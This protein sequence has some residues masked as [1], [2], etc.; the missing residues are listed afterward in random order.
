MRRQP[1]LTTR[2]ARPRQL[3]TDTSHAV[4]TRECQSDPP[5]LPRDAR[6]P[7]PEPLSTNPRRALDILLHV[8]RPRTEAHGDRAAACWQLRSA[9][10]ALAEN[11]EL[12]HA[13][14]ADSKVRTVLLYPPR[15]RAEAAPARPLDPPV[16]SA[17]Q[18]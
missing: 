9:R 6:H 8:S 17:G 10:V 16:A 3:P 5:S 2:D 13:T 18:W 14:D 15:R 7:T 4:P 1:R 12:T 11:H